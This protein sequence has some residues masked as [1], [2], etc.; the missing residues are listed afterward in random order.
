MNRKQTV[1]Q[2]RLV[3]TV[4]ATIVLFGLGGCATGP[5]FRELRLEGQRALI[6]RDF[7]VARGLFKEAEK[8]VP[9]DAL[10]LHDL[11]DCCLYYAR[12]RF[13]RR[14][15]P[16]A[17]REVDRGIAY[18]DRA[19]RSQP[20]F[21]AA[22]LGKNIALELKG[23]FE[24]AMGVAEWAVK[25]VGPSAKQQIFL[26]REL[27]E[28]GDP[29]AALLRLQQAVAMEPQNATAHAE[30][31]MFFLRADKRARAAAHLRRAYQLDPGHR[32]VIDALARIGEPVPSPSQALG[33]R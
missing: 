15:Y 31:G 19:I 20:G 2:S 24:Q 17:M 9:K 18:Y 28:R 14:N 3:R 27:E 7:A 21:S 16:A 30:L 13:E 6:D 33:D 8:Q 10:N 32:G 4:F 26:A 12:D 11:G 29:D 1:L 5:D 23:Q 25:F 22:L